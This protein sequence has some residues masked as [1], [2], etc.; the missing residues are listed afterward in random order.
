MIG[1]FIDFEDNPIL[2]PDSDIDSKG[3]FNPAVIREGKIYFM[4]YRAQS[5]KD[6]LTGRIALARS[7]DGFHFTKYPEPVMVPDREFDR[8]GCEDPRIVK[9]KDTYYLTYVGNPGKYEVGNI[10]LATSKDLIH[11]EKH[12]SI[13]KPENKWDKGQVKAGAIL[14]FKING[15]YIMY[16]MGESEPWKTAIGIAVSD[17]LFHWKEFLDHPV[18]LPRKGHFDEKGV[19]PGPPPFI[20]R[21]GIWLIYCGWGE[22]CVYK[23]GA[24]LFSLKE[25]FKVLKRTK[26]PIIAKGKNWGKFFGGI[27]NH[28]VAESLIIEDNRWLLY[29]GAADRACCVA[30]WERL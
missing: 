7:E 4:F 26:D 13:L 2:M 11:W 20:T 10:C 16:F 29:Y 9:I 12:G 30:V 1:P 22:D 14:P 27:S 17:D 5:K 19:E 8:F 23:V 3:A 21:E 24:V 6:S 25:P 18:I 28:Y 15:K